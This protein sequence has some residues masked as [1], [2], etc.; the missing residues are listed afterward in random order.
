MTGVQTCALPI[1]LAVP[2][3]EHYLPLLHVLGASDARDTLSFPVTGMDMAAIGMRCCL[4][5]PTAVN[6]SL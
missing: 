4:C 5:L 2:T 6:T 1:W 3:P